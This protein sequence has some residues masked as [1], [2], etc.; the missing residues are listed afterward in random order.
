MADFIRLF[1]P[2]RLP[3]FGPL[4]DGGLRFNNPLQLALWELPTIWPSTPKPSI[5]V[6]VG[7][8]YSTADPW[9]DLVPM[10]GIIQDGFGP[11]LFRSLMA[12]PSLHGHN[13]WLATING[14]EHSSQHRYHRLDLSLDGGKPEMDDP[15]QMPWLQSQVEK[16]LCTDQGH[17]LTAQ[18]LRAAS[19]YFELDRIPTKTY[20]YYLCQGNVLC[21]RSP[22]FVDDMISEFPEAAMVIDDAKVLGHLMDYTRCEQCRCFNV[23]VSFKVKALSE[24]VSMSLRLARD[25]LWA[26][27]GFPHDMSWFIDQQKLQPQTK[28]ERQTSGGACRCSRA[29]K[30]RRL[31]SEYHMPQPKHQKAM[32]S[33]RRSKEHPRFN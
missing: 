23:S 32:G 18:A 27:N 14:I 6:S 19:F 26:I 30:K 13:S 25:D 21:R 3:V 17:L 24:C 33:H 7:T 5:A 1:P 15:S 9:T 29:H 8:G 31:P 10:R 4:Q 22:G 20:G 16:H 28:P 11:R 12:S 2:K